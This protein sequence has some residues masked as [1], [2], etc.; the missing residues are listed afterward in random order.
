MLE[1]ER[2]LGCRRLLPLS[3]PRQDGVVQAVRGE[4]E[5]EEEDGPVDCAL[6][7]ARG[8]AH[9]V[10]VEQR[11]QHEGEQRAHRA[12]HEGR[13]RPE[14]RH[15]ARDRRQRHQ[16][17]DAARVQG[18]PLH[19]AVDV[20]ALSQPPARRQQPR[21]HDLVDRVHHHREC[22]RQRDAQHH[23]QEK[24]AIF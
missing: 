15:E 13:E 22:Q 18:R 11:G 19:G 1:W 5:A 23:L 6:R 14:R 21:L 4:R 9:D 3:V 7:G 16:H 10:E 8:V 12:P 24:V 17:R 2:A 20:A